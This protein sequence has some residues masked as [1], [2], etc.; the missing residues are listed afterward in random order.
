MRR[1]SNQA[2]R[3]WRKWTDAPYADPFPAPPVPWSRA[4][5]TWLFCIDL[6]ALAGLLVTR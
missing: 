5:L 3:S 6:G 2:G 1:W 4:I